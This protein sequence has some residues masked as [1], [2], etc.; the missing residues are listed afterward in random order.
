[1]TPV[2]I[3]F[4]VSF[5]LALTLLF[6]QWLEAQGEDRRKTIGG[7]FRVCLIVVCILLDFHA[8]LRLGSAGGG[9][10]MGV[11]GVRPPLMTA[12]GSAETMPDDRPPPLRADRQPGPQP[13]RSL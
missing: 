8:H 13:H 1:V 2:F 3:F 5:W 6:L 12:D 11:E 10:G 7:A 4:A 9:D